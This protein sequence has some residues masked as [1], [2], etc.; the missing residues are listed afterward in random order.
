M[1][2]WLKLSQRCYNDKTAWSRRKSKKIHE[3]KNAWKIVKDN[4]NLRK[5]QSKD[6]YD[7]Q[8]QLTITDFL[9]KQRFCDEPR[10]SAADNSASTKGATPMMGKTATI[11]GEPN[12]ATTQGRC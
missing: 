4:Y 12:S 9:I 7:T 2:L 8:K 10:K 11:R 6:F 5:K 3:E 1:W